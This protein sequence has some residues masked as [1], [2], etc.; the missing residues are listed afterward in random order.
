MSVRYEQSLKDVFTLVTVAWSDH[1]QHEMSPIRTCKI[2]DV[3]NE[4]SDAVLHVIDEAFP[5]D[6]AKSWLR[7]GPMDLLDWSTGGELLYD[8]PREV[9]AAALRRD[10]LVRLRIFGNPPGI[11]DP[12]GTYNGDLCEWCDETRHLTPCEHCASEQEHP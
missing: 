2:S 7:D 6:D 9:I 10:A 8:T 5:P 3:C 1:A 12:A 4:L 11:A